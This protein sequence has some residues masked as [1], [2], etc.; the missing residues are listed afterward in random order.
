MTEQADNEVD[1]LFEKM[2]AVIPSDID[3]RYVVMAAMRMFMH[4][5]LECCPSVKHFEDLLQKMLKAF[6]TNRKKGEEDER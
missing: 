6:I 1:A 2:H 5:S 4:G 3:A